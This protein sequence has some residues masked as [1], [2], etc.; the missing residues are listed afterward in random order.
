MQ[1]KILIWTLKENPP[2]PDGWYNYERIRFYK[3]LRWRCSEISEKNNVSSLQVGD[4]F[5]HTDYRA[6]LCIA[7]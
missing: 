7:N 4:L 5:I 6:F 3:D 2:K 1:K